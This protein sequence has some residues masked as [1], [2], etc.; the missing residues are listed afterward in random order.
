MSD[1]LK[2]KGNEAFSSKDYTVA[3]ELYGH[4]ITLNPADAVL[5]SNKAMALIKLSSWK[6]CVETCDTGLSN[7]PDKKTKLK[8]FWRR[9]IAYTQLNDFKNARD[10]YEQ[11]LHNEANNSS[12]LKSID[13]LNA[14]ESQF[15]RSHSIEEIKSE[16]K[17][18][19]DNGL[20]NIPIYEVDQ[21][22]EEFRD[23]S[24]K[25]SKKSTT[26]K[27]TTQPQPVQSQIQVNPHSAQIPV[28]TNILSKPSNYPE[29]PTIHQL[30]TISKCSV[31]ERPFA[32]RYLSS[33]SPEVYKAI[34]S[35]GSIESSIVN[36]IL[37]SI[38]F[39]I[40]AGCITWDYI[41]SLLNTLS[42]APRFSLISMFCD[43]QKLFK[44]KEG[45][46]TLDAAANI[47]SKEVLQK[48]NI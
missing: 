13:E 26:T 19:K 27:Q 42:S 21:L 8:L 14:Q 17:P 40:D 22:P 36:F 25:P 23:S 4:A 10:S 24:S 12:V 34:F 11:A 35:G 6:E 39:S 32:Y 16:K 29:K 48:W 15:K 33:L 28:S 30:L 31:D 47:K 20:K 2:A 1:I 18:K 37:D 5:Y 41:V 38:I 45:L 7:S 9:G 46:V 3:A 44:I 43:K